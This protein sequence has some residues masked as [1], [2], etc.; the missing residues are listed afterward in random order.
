MED[1]QYLLDAYAKFLDL[2]DAHRGHI[3]AAALGGSHAEQ[4]TA[5]MKKDAFEIG[6]TLIQALPLD[7]PVLPLIH[8]VMEVLAASIYELLEKG[9]K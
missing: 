8:C 4:L 1:N 2:V 9:D 6:D 7:D 3:I 5:I